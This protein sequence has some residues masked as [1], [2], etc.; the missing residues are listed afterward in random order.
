MDTAQAMKRLMTICVASFACVASASI[1]EA[2]RAP[3]AKDVAYP[4]T[5]VLAVDVTDLDHRVF[6]VTERIPVHPGSLTLLY[7]QWAP[8]THSAYGTIAAIGGLVITA[9]GRRLEWTRD[10]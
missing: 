7:P 1:V 3:E 10:S 4:G 2:A 8:G 5:I 9:R 6:S